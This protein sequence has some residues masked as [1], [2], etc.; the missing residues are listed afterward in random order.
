MKLI[1]V[2]A[3]FSAV[4]SVAAVYVGS[5]SDYTFTAVP[6]YEIEVSPNKTIIARGTIEQIR[7]QALAHNPNWDEEYYHPAQKLANERYQVDLA[8][9]DTNSTRSTSTL[10]KRLS[11]DFD[12]L[13]ITCGGRWHAVSYDGALR[14]ALRLYGI[15][16]KPRNGPGPGNCGRVGCSY[17]TSIVWCNDN[18]RIK[19]L[20]SFDEIADGA[21]AI[22]EK[23]SYYKFGGGLKVSGQAFN[24]A[25][26]NVILR[27]ED[28]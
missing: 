27:G 12:S 11:K 25:N 14:E 24:K 15:K 13:R 1:A 23:C 5:P 19:T 8:A 6:E 9:D 10:D 28:C 22:M 7:E 20:S 2:V 21:F 26:W 17:G 3:F 4:C 18:Q 16:G